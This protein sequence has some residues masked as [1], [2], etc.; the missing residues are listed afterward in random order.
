MLHPRDVIRLEPG[1]VVMLDQ[2]RLP[3]ERVDRRCKS[4]DAL[5][6]AIR[7]LA[8]R[9]APALGVAAAMGMSLAAERSTARDLA[10][11]RIELEA[12]SRALAASR[13]TAVNL[14]WA[15]AGAGRTVDSASD[16]DALR[17]D[18]RA[19]ALRIHDD[20]EARCRAMGAHGAGLLPRGARILTHC[21]AGALATGGYGSALGV[22]RAAFERD[23]SIHVWVD[24]TRPLL[25]GARLTAWELAEDG[26]PHT[27]V[28]DVA[29]G[30]LFSRGLVD[31]VVF[32]A[33]R[34]ARN[35]DAANKI[36]SYTLSVLAAAHDVP[37]YVVA[38]TSTIDASLASGAGIPIEERGADE[39]AGYGGVCWASPDSPVAN[40]AFDVTPAAN[41][42]AIVTELGVHRAPFE[43][44][45]VPPPVLAGAAR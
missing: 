37:L 5:V 16:A 17:K 14:G 42:T 4:V 23:P 32:G 12:A 8:I 26:I 34:I 21:N 22:V 2:T 33:D 25:Q 39:V 10:S 15:L 40:P 13:P 11:L 1:A 18:L 44:S 29:A 19:L 31:A 20:E 30:Q 41:V 43:A 6:E 36:G 24:E 9:G 7:V 35:G 3:H 45:L 27:L 38:P 28:A